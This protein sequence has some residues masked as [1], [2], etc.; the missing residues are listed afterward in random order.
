LWRS[1]YVVIACA[2]LFAAG[3]VAV[4]STFASFS[5]ETDNS[6]STFPGGW[7]GP[8]TSAADAPSGY[9]ASLT[10][11]PGTHGPVTGQSLYWLDNGATSTCPASGYSLL[12][13]MANASTASYTA[14]NPYSTT[15]SDKVGVTTLATTLPTPTTLNGAIN[16][17]VTSVT[18]TSS[19][20]MPNAPF[21]I[22]VDT[23]ANLE[24][25]HVT[26]KAGNVL[27]VTRGQDGTTAVSHL[28]GVTVNVATVALTAATTFPSTNGY[29]FQIGSED[30]TVLSG[31]GTATVIVTRGALSTTIATHTN[32]TAL[33]QIS[34]PVANGTDFPQA[35][36]FTILVDSEQMTVTSGQGT[37]AVTWIVTRGA[38]STTIA[39][40]ASGAHVFQTADPIGGHNFCYQ[41]VSTSASNWTASTVFPA[42]Q[43]GLVMTGFAI[44][45]SVTANSQLNVGD[46]ITATF[47]QSY[48]GISTIATSAVI[49][50][51]W[52][53][54]GALTIYLNDVAYTA[55]TCSAASTAY[56]VKITGLNN[57]QASASTSIVARATITISSTTA[58]WTITTSGPVQTLTGTAVGTPVQTLLSTATTDQSIACI[59][60]TYHCTPTATGHGF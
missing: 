48:S 53:A 10:W 57:G 31:A 37:G 23:G 19:A 41:M 33:N 60:A 4:G 15:L 58:T 30:M 38:N 2:V 55:G 25:M 24:D 1:P 42:A 56:K 13:T 45:T 11:T 34:V 59:S 22:Q 44:N 20:G 6:T 39:S 14:S 21:E 9:D 36:N 47:N 43:M 51:S 46:V 27:T 17:S 12:A 3:A 5:A 26:A 7:I 52:T 18:V 35:G 29:T 54:A 28:T 8:A 16:N 32:A 40:H 50:E 49:C